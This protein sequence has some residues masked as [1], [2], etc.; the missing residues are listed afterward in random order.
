MLS[1]NDVN[2]RWQIIV[3][4]K[5]EGIKVGCDQGKLTVVTFSDGQIP[6]QTDKHGHSLDSIIETMSNKKIG[7]KAFH[8]A[9]CHRTNFIHWS[10]KQM[11]YDGIKEVGFEEIINI[12]KYR[13]TI[14]KMLHWV[15]TEIRDT[16]KSET[17]RA[18][19]LFTLQSSPCRSQRCS[20]CS[21]VRKSNRKGKL[22][23]CNRC[24]MIMDADLNA[25]KNHAIDLPDIPLWLRES[26]LNRKGFLWTPDGFFDLDGVELRVPLVATIK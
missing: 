26:G 15:N 19:V 18:G 9:T 21:I 1:E 17:D 7:S 3:E 25:S 10:V 5:K 12:N 6:L 24:G 14:R 2:F 13:K 20:G 16:M 22:Y 4:P 8:K 11:K 23:T